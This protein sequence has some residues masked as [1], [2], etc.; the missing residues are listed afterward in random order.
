MLASY[1]YFV[2]KR[3]RF[4]LILFMFFSTVSGSLEGVVSNATLQALT[5]T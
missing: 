4:S 1:K 5:A 2:S 3:A